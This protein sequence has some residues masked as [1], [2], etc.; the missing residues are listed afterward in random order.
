MYRGG[1]F[2]YLQ[3][4][5]KVLERQANFKLTVTQL[6]FSFPLLSTLLRMLC[7]F[8]PLLAARALT[9]SAS[10]LPYH[11]GTWTQPALLLSLRFSHHHPNSS[12]SKKA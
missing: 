10:P 2:Q 11:L 9:G 4:H 3:M 1:E 8:K 12:E 6:R 5:L 7:L